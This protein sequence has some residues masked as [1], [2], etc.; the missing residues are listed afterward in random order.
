MVDERLQDKFKNPQDPLRI[1]FV[2]SMW[3]TGFDVPSLSTVYL[4]KP[5][6]NHTLMQ[7]ITR[8]N[9]VFPD[10]NNGLIVVYVDVFSNLQKALAIY[11]VGSKRGDV[12]AA[13]HGT[14]STIV[15]RIRG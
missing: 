9:S 10:K 12:R 11:A 6:R 2:C 7:T 4:D 15:T 3:T 14:A 13:P 5:L 1:A 8:A